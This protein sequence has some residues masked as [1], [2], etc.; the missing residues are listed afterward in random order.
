M[1]E[2]LWNPKIERMPREEIKEL[3]VKRIR[4]QLNYVYFNSRWYKEL[5]GEANAHPEDVKTLEG[6]GKLI[7]I[8]RKDNLREF[9]RKTGD[10]YNGLRCVPESHLVQYWSSSGTTGKPTFGAY[11]KDDLN[12]AIESFVRSYWDGGYRPGMKAF[13]INVN[14]PWSA[15]VF[16]GMFEILRLTVCFDFFPPPPLVSRAAKCFMQHKFDCI[17]TAGSEVNLDYLPHLLSEAGYDPIEVLSSIKVMTM[18]GE[19]L[20]TKARELLKEYYI[21]AKIRDL[22]GCGETYCWAGETCDEHVGGHI[23]EDIGYPELVDPD[24]GE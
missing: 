10:P 12:V 8:F 19:P 13:A 3:Q 1:S 5:Y 14:F 15:P 11:T 24:T 23:W 21:N 4:S 6:F 22:A 17:P 20:T 2:D 7:P 18:I 9:V 16:Y